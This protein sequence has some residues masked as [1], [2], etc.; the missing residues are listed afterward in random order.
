MTAK[1]FLG[2]IKAGFLGLGGVR[3]SIA[4]VLNL[5]GQRSTFDGADSGHILKVNKD[6]DV[7][8]SAIEFSVAGRTATQL[9]LIGDENFTL[10][11]GGESTPITAMT[12]NNRTGVVDFPNTPNMSGPSLSLAAANAIAAAHTLELQQRL[13]LEGGQTA[14]TILAVGYVHDNGAADY[15]PGMKAQIASLE[16]GNVLFV[17]RNGDRFL[18]NDPQEGPIHLNL[19]EIYVIQ[20]L[21]PGS[22]I[23]ASEGA[24]GFSQQANGED[25]S[26][27]PLLSLALAFTKTSFYFFRGATSYRGPAGGPGTFEGWIHVVGGALDSTVSLEAPDSAGVYSTVRGQENIAVPAWGYQRFYAD[28]NKEYRL[29]AT[30]PIMACMNAN[31]GTEPG[32]GDS[33]LILPGTTDGITWGAGSRVLTPYGSTVFSWFTNDAVAGGHV[34]RPGDSTDLEMISRADEPGYRA[35]GAVRIIA[36]GPITSY[37][38]ADAAGSEA[39][40]MPAV[41]TFSQRLAIPLTVELSGSTG[42]NNIAIASP[43]VGTARLYQWDV[44]FRGGGEACDACMSREPTPKRPPSISSAGAPPAR[45]GPSALRNSSGIPPRPIFRQR[46]ATR[47]LISF[48]RISRGAIWRPTCPVWRYSTPC[49]TRDWGRRLLCIGARQAP[50]SAA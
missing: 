9:G 11:A 21:G 42:S 16:R 4:D 1:D 40:A 23:T 12:V 20:N 35:R 31:M 38:G 29:T 2:G 5:K 41:A 13:L 43:Y 46:P 30:T 10:R 6:T 47:I 44:V 22:I 36:Q 26:P 39:T 27:M 33:R 17:Y 34:T 15:T 3:G 19:G 32:F 49:K 24:Y 18:A 50:R 45:K 8:D 28:G 37:S 48:C 14:K 25:V 7:L